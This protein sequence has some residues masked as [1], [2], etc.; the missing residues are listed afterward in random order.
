MGDVDLF[1][2]WSETLQKRL[3][4]PGFM[5]SCGLPEQGRRFIG[6]TLPQ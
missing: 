5:I 6:A 3:D 1:G 4:R 2:L